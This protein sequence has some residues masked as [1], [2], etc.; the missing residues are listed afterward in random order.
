MTGCIRRGPRARS[1]WPDDHG[2]DARA[3][4]SR[5]AALVS[6]AAVLGVLLALAPQRAAALNPDEARGVFTRANAAYAKQ[7]YAGAYKLYAE[8]ADS[9]VR[10]PEV[11]YNLGN[12]CA[13]LGKTGEAVLYYERARAL[14]PRDPDLMANLKRVAPPDNFPKPFILAAPFHR[15]LEGFSVREWTALFLSLWIVAGV[16]G[17]ALFLSPGGAARRWLRRVLWFVGP[18]AVVA[19]VFAGVRLND[20]AR[21]VHAIVTKP[22]TIVYSGPDTG[23]S[24][25]ASATEGTKVRRLPFG[26]SPAWVQVRLMDGQK[27]FV[28]ALDIKPI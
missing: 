2:R 22:K 7:D 25:I 23:F 6:A 26:G 20:N 17:A 15:A 19:G 9:G 21:V 1:E 4:T 28:S 12:A 24:M 13:R 5:I 18:A 27:G 3:T 14:A 8:I 10:S 16:V 11:F